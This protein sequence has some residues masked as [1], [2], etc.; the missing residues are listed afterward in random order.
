[1]K[2]LIFNIIS[3]VLL[4]VGFA[5]SYQ[6]TN[7]LG[8]GNEK[9][10]E[11][12]TIE[13]TEK[14]FDSLLEL[15]SKMYNSEIETESLDEESEDELDSNEIQFKNMTFE[16][17]TI[18]SLQTSTSADDY[19]ENS[20]TNL[21]RTM[22][23]YFTEEASYYN[24]DCYVSYEEVLK[25]S[26]IN[27]REYYTLDLDMELYV[28]V[29]DK[30]V[31]MK[32]NNF[33][34]SLLSQNSVSETS[35]TY[36]FYDDYNS[37]KAKGKWIDFSLNPSIAYEYINSQEGNEKI[38]EI[39]Y[40]YIKA[41]NQGENTFKQTGKKYQLQND[42]FKSFLT[43][44]FNENNN[45][46]V[47]EVIGTIDGGLSITLPGEEVIMSIL[48]KY[49][50]ENAGT[51]K[52]MYEKDTFEIKNINNTVIEGFDKVEVINYFDLLGVNYGTTN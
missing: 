30:K 37:I 26:S 52:Q 33:I 28:S 22:K 14:V 9:N 24:I 43:A 49:N 8:A 47:E 6:K 50:D 1:M 18:S 31:F 16:E 34:F 44:I 11:V 39:I 35:K 27:N 40:S 17:K 20:K 48:L 21:K 51:K 12:E 2:K 3:V 13:K 4:V 42:C 10:E 32:I 5:C 46:E 41:H 19:Y 25:S 36:N 45:E 38:F 29:V 15:L 23:C 7:Y